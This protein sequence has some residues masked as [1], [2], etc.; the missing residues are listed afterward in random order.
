ML[1]IIQISTDDCMNPDILSAV[2]QAGF[3][4][5]DIEF[6]KHFLDD[7]VWYDNSRRLQEV[8]ERAELTAAQVHLPFYG[9][10]VSSERYEEEMERKIRN[11]L[12]S[13]SVLGIKWGAFH[14]MSSTNYGYDPKRAMYDNTEKLK[15]YLETA[16]QCNVGIAVENIPIFPDCPQYHFFTADPEDHIALV[17]GLQSDHIG[18]CWDFGH[19][20]LMPYDKKQV[21][22]RLGERVKIVHI[23]NNFETY[24]LHL[25]P[26]I[27]SVDW[28][29]LLPVLGGGHF[30]GPFSL[31]VKLTRANE[32]LWNDYLN[33]CGLAADKLMKFL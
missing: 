33:F 15:K 31:E 9:I 32:A 28:Q 23:H 25:C 10:F 24:D 6:S 22:E 14:P 26:A 3:D 29:T 11:A 4:G 8:L 20:N 16:E 21:L 27:G 19:A 18:I 7:P 1:K 12:K 17:D 30:S 13:M 5:I 2:R